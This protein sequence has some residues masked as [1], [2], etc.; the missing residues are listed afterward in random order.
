MEKNKEEQIVPLWK[1]YSLTIQEASL[2]FNIGEKTIRS[3]I[4][5][6]PD[7]DFYLLIGNK[8]LIKREKFERFLDKASA[9]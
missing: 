3:T 8:H 5:L 7:S 1:K 9:L 6:H 2:L 4:D